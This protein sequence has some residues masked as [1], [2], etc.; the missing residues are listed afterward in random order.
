M[1]VDLSGLVEEKYT[2]PKEMEMSKNIKNSMYRES[3]DVSRT[4][5]HNK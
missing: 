2:K 4:T 3:L 5:V 1:E